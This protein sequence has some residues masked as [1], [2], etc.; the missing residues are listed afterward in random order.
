MAPGVVSAC[1]VRAHGGA[2]CAALDAGEV[3]AV[4]GEQQTFEAVAQ[5]GSQSEIAAF[6]GILKTACDR[7]HGLESKLETLENKK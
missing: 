6:L 2:G 5:P 7:L 1:L 4:S 3:G